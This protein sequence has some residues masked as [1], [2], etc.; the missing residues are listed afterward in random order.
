MPSVMGPAGLSVLLC[1]V[2]VTKG[3]L[4]LREASNVGCS[5]QHRLNHFCGEKMAEGN[6]QCFLLT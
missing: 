5:Q 4:S 1:F 6:H 3:H 2:S